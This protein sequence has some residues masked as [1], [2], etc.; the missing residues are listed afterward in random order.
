MMQSWSRRPQSPGA[1]LRHQFAAL[2]VHQG[3]KSQQSGGG[4]SLHYTTFSPS[5][6]FLNSVVR[7]PHGWANQET[8]QKVAVSS[9]S[10]KKKMG[11]P[12]RIAEFRS[13]NP[14]GAIMFYV[15]LPCTGGCPWGYVNQQTPKG[16][17]KIEGH[18]KQFQ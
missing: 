1:S 5:V 15:S 4:R 13:K 6:S 2:P 3:R 12:T 14:K 9:G 7:R 18:V 11:A 10:P 8:L 17:A 16:A